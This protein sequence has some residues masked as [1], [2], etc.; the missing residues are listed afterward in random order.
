MVGLEDD[1]FLLKWTLFRRT[2]LVFRGVTQKNTSGQIKIFNQPRF[3]IRGPISFTKSYLL[4]CQVRK[5][6]VNILVVFLRVSKS[7]PPI[8]NPHGRKVSQSVWLPRFWSHPDI[9]FGVNYGWLIG[10][11]DEVGVHKK[12]NN[13]YISIYIY[14][15]IY[16][17]QQYDM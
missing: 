13:I 8:H 14:M 5:N 3:P 1:P 10:D 17:L 2:M 12:N 9:T 16:I 4:G 15:Y 11:S 7:H 6:F